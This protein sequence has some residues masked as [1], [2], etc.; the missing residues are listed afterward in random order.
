MIT[1]RN[2]LFAGVNTLIEYHLR[3]LN[4]V[5]LNIVHYYLNKDHFKTCV[6][7]KPSL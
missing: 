2:L 1:L 7:T 5:P 3:K 4:A 6:I